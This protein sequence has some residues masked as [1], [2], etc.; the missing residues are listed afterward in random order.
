L[1]KRAVRNSTDYPETEYDEGNVRKRI[2]TGN[3]KE[4][5]FSPVPR[6]HKELKRRSRKIGAFPNDGSGI[7]SLSIA[8][9]WSSSSDNRRIVMGKNGTNF[10]AFWFM[11]FVS[12][13]NV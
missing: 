5:S 10:D 2:K 8:W 11:R 1:L 3:A 13:G 6:V 7:F 4:R 9:F 12:R